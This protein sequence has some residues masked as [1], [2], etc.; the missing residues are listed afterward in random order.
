MKEERKPGLLRRL[1]SGISTLRVFVGNALFLLILGFV[2]FLLFSSGDDAVRVPDGGA[3]VLRLDAPVMEAR[4][5]LDPLA[6]LFADEDEPRPLVLRDLLEVIEEGTK[7]D[8][9]AALVLDLSSFPG[10]APATLRAIGDALDDF[11]A[12]GKPVLVGADRLDQGR[13]Y[14]ASFADQLYLNPMGQ[15]ML[16]GFAIQPVYYAELLEKLRVNVNLFRVGTY[17]SA[18][19]PFIRNDMSDAARESNSALAR[20]LW[21]EW[22]D[23]VAANR[24]LPP[25]QLDA[26]INEQPERLRAVDG[27]PARLALEAGL[28]DELLTR[29]AF[30]ARLV[31]LVGADEED[32]GFRGIGHR[33]YLRNRH[34]AQMAS[35]GDASGRVGVIV[36]EGTI[37]GGNEPGEV[38]EATAEL[39]RNAR[40]N[41]DLDALVLRVNSPGGSAF[42]SEVV[43]RELELAQ[44]SGKP[45]VVSMGGVAA[46]G[47]YWISATA[48][49]IFAE[50]DT[51]T[52]SIGIFGLLPTF[53]DSADAL[54]IH[55]DGVGTHAL[56]G[57]GNLLQ[58]INPALRDMLQLATE[59]GYERFL[60]V[61]ARGSG[62]GTG[63][64]RRDRSG[65]GLAGPHRDGTGPRGPARRPRRGHVRGRG[66]GRTRGLADGLSGTAA[67][68]APDP[69]GASVRRS[70]SRARRRA[71]G[72]PHGTRPAVRRRLDRPPAGSA[73]AAAGS[74][75]RLCPLRGLSGQDELRPQ[76][77][78]AER[79]LHR[80]GP[81][82]RRHSLGALFPKRP[83]IVRCS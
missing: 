47:G 60:D 5:P 55:S 83:D 6:L 75:R 56:S 76:T 61:V 77:G 34:L 20:G 58:P 80:K 73:A 21:T 71:A 62:D 57:A 7:D 51:I 3:L 22:R 32:A 41:G 59:H 13:Y 35:T 78:G 1:G 53:E 8:R 81:D 27:D 9:I 30:R 2:L 14:L 45:V 17:K 25:E 79:V 74:G 50:A 4:P 46:S 72:R 23:R 54:G 19:E 31:D 16:S 42:F 33:A 28:V 49:R 26:I 40:E 66:T 10:A 24:G 70:R 69:D 52:G 68:A 48:D 65:P 12:S 18:V 44:L 64:G 39:I 29:D 82:G 36:A 67:V 63:R 37:T 15:V 43:R 11:R 38:G